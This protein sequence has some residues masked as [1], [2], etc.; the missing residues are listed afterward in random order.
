MAGAGDYK[1]RVMHLAQ[2][3]VKSASGAENEVFPESGPVYWCNISAAESPKVPGGKA[4]A[5]EG[6][7]DDYVK[8]MQQMIIK[9]RNNI[10]IRTM[11]RLV[12]LRSSIAYEVTGVR[13]GDNETIV[14]VEA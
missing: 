1:H 6:L 13:I 5:A 2:T 14:N 3:S 4:G 9:I 8:S 10:S 12:D 11:D 7:E